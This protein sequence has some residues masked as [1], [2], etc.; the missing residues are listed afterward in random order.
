MKN[1]C[2]PLNPICINWPIHKCAHVASS[3]T[4]CTFWDISTTISP[5][6]YDHEGL[7]ISRRALKADREPVIL[8]A[9]LWLIPVQGAGE[10]YSFEGFMFR[11]KLLGQIPLH[12]EQCESYSE[13]VRVRRA[14]TSSVHARQ[15]YRILWEGPECQPVTPPLDSRGFECFCPFATNT[16]THLPDSCRHWHHPSSPD[17][18]DWRAG[19]VLS[20]SAVVILPRNLGPPAWYDVAY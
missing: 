4:P 7:I 9:S 19:H 18:I 6:E 12:R 3:S 10:I 2:V 13:H 1:T 17:G 5:F 20:T 15:R 8:L 16:A 14:L 11:A